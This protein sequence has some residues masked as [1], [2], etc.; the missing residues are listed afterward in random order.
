MGAVKDEIKG[1]AP[2]RKAQGS[3]QNLIDQIKAQ[4]DEVSAM[5]IQK[6]NDGV[7]EGKDAQ[8]ENRRKASLL[9]ATYAFLR[10]ARLLLEDY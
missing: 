6:D 5:I 2:K 8:P 7:T 10:E 3:T 9:R 4:E 1:P